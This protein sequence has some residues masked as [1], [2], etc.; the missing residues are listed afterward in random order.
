MKNYFLFFCKKVLP[1]IILIP[2]VV[3]VYGLFKPLPK[4][5]SLNGPVRNVEDI[6]FLR[7]LTYQKNGETVRDQQIFK[8]VNKLIQDADEFIVMDMFLFNDEYERKVKYPTIS[9]NLTKALIEKKNKI[10]LSKL[11]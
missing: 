11:S 5:T 4:D 9:S 10:N 1:F 2:V 6:T 8:E 7:D 3:S